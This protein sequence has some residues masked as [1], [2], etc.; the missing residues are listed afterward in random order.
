MAF[1]EKIWN[2]SGM[3][4][5]IDRHI[6]KIFLGYFIGGLIA[7]LTIFLAV[8]AMSMMLQFP[9]VAGSSFLNYYAFYLP[10]IDNKLIP[11]AS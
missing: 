8:D 5:L 4:M 6:M 2:S 1:D 11:V 10:D 9:D 3:L 7:F